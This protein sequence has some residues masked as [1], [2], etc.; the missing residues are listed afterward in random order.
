MF[1]SFILRLAKLFQQ[2]FKVFIQRMK[3][4][5]RSTQSAP[6]MRYSSKLNE[7]NVDTLR[8]KTCSK[9]AENLALGHGG[10]LMCFKLHVCRVCVQ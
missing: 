7:E 9:S 4:R 8:L 6:Q 2:E 10:T 1:C 3:L 5:E